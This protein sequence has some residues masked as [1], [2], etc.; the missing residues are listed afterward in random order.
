MEEEKENISILDKID[1]LGDSAISRFTEL[2]MMFNYAQKVQNEGFASAVSSVEK[3]FTE[4]GEVL[5]DAQKIN[6]A[7]IF[8]PLGI[9]Y[10]NKDLEEAVSDIS[11]TGKYDNNNE[12]NGQV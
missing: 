4:C 12:N 8:D 10:S 1:S 3:V 5:N 2:G 11:R 6:N 9:P 7:G